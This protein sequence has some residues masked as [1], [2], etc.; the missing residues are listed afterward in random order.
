MKWYH[1]LQKVL[2]INHQDILRK[3]SW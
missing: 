2:N 3:T 1:T